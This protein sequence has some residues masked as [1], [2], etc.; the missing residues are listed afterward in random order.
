MSSP[1]PVVSDLFVVSPLGQEQT[2]KPAKPPAGGSAAIGLAIPLDLTYPKAPLKAVELGWI[3][4]KFALVEAK[5]EVGYNAPGV[6]QGTLD[7]KHK[8][9]KGSHSAQVGAALAYDLN[10]PGAVRKHIMD[11]LD[12]QAKVKV[13]QYTPELIHL[14]L[15]DR[16]KFFAQLLR[17]MDIVFAGAF[18]TNIDWMKFVGVGITWDPDWCFGSILLPLTF[19]IHQSEDKRKVI[20]VS[21]GLN[22]KFGP[23]K[24]LWWEILKRRGAKS[25]LWSFVRFMAETGTEMAGEAASEA[26]KAA[27]KA[28]AQAVFAETGKFGG[29]VAM[30]QKI[31]IRL[32]P[33]IEWLGIVSWA[34]PIA[35]QMMEF[36]NQLCKAAR[37]NGL[38]DGQYLTFCDTYIRTIYGIEIMEDF[39]S[40]IIKVK[41]A[42]IDKALRD[43]DLHSREGLIAYLERNLNDSRPIMSGGTVNRGAAKAMAEKLWL[44]MRERY[45]K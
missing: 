37:E 2:P 45:V 22:L 44:Q 24:K 4:F 8:P 16:K 33:F 43:C 20:R 18:K 1:N 10:D 39:R 36:S 31:A 12:A 28:A 13:N 30:M 6:V 29:K 19:V 17:H 32:A 27:S 15:T 25:V 38:L 14:F 35:I 11:R 26:A 9:L 23:S 7:T 34:V 3:R 41:Q 21:G 5:Y 40:D 42:A